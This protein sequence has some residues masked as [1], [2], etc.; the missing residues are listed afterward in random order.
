ML[1]CIFAFSGCDYY[2]KTPEYNTDNDTNIFQYPCS[3]ATLIFQMT[4][5][6]NYQL[7]DMAQQYDYVTPAKA[8]GLYNLENLIYPSLPD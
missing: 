2:T 8:R 6:S 4:E 7:T 5:N 1:I 3:E